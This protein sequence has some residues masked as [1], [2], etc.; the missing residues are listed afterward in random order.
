ML[1]GKQRMLLSKRNPGFRK[2]CLWQLQ[3]N[4]T[5]PSII[6]AA[7]QAELHFK[8]IFEEDGLMSLRKGR[9]LAGSRTFHKNRSLLA[10]HYWQ[11]LPD[12]E[13]YST[14]A[15]W[16]QWIFTIHHMIDL[17]VSL[18]TMY[19][20]T[21]YHIFNKKKLEACLIFTSRK[22]SNI[23]HCIPGLGTEGFS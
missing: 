7:K 8:H 4:F 17:A 5:S 18:L 16:Q 10:I 13:P 20:T 1:C 15:F 11:F 12:K 14:R 22:T 9:F 6:P 2:C 23:S 19:S 21:L 3:V